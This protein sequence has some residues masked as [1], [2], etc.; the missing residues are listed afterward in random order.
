VSNNPFR[1]AI[2]GAGFCGTM[3]AVHLLRRGFTRP[4]EISLIEAFPY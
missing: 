3:I 4:V 1:I 2:V